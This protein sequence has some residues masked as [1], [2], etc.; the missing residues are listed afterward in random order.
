MGLLQQQQVQTDIIFNK[1]KKLLKFVN[2][3]RKREGIDNYYPEYWGTQCL[4][5]TFDNLF[6]LCF[7]YK[8]GASFGITQLL[9]G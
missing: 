3:W 8:N 6:R 7:V 5:I 1:D 9:N 4:K 2:N